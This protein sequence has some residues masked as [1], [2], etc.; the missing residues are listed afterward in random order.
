MKKMKHLLHEMLR[1]RERRHAQV[2]PWTA[3]DVALAPRMEVVPSSNHHDL[4]VVVYDA[5]DVAAD[6]V[7]VSTPVADEYCSANVAPNESACIDGLHLELDRL[8]GENAVLRRRNELLEHCHVRPQMAPDRAPVDIFDDPSEPPPEASPWR[9]GC[10]SNGSEVA[11]DCGSDICDTSSSSSGSATPPIPQQG[12]GY[13][14]MWLPMQAVWA[15]APNGVMNGNEQHLAR[16]P[17]I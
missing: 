1:W 4:L 16:I 10:L 8:R 17:G 11:T 9:P 2:L 6:E 7:A 15:V 5:P 14:V 3:I 13:V 12:F